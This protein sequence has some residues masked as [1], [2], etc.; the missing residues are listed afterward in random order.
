[1]PMSDTTTTEG[2][3][4]EQELETLRAE[5]SRMCVRIDHLVAERQRL[6]EALEAIVQMGVV[7]DAKATH[8]KRVYD[9]A[10]SALSS[11]PA[12]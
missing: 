5:N 11:T 10:S 7:F 1:M 6:R 3:R 8:S 12:T 2:L 4:K 9:L